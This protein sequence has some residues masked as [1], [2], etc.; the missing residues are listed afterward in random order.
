MFDQQPIPLP[1]KEKAWPTLARWVG[2]GVI[3]AASYGGGA[4]AVLNWPQATSSASEPPPAVM[5]ELAELPVSS[6][7]TPQEVAPGELM[8][9]AQPEETKDVPEPVKE[10]TEEPEPEPVPET[11][12]LVEQ[13]EPPP[14]PLPEPEIEVPDLPQIPLA[15]AVLTPPPPQPEKKVEKK[16]TPKEK[17][18]RKKTLSRDKLQAPRTTA[19]TASQAQ[20]ASRTAAPHSGASSAPSMS[21]ASWR[22]MLMAH[23]NRHKRF[24]PG[25]ST[26]TAVV[27]FRIDRG[28]RVVS[29]RLVRSSGDSALDAAAVG[30]V[31]R[32][33]PVPAPPSNM[34][35]GALSLT[36]PVRFNR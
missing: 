1:E 19:P 25:G 2:A 30:L 9:E 3:V 29:A 21:P 20:R 5:I 11:P 17:V 26:G 36:V 34:G 10:V 18:Q 12:K 4:W 6:Q 13:R 7:A 33:S 24:P 16:P 32:A 28:G 8:T 35:A 23:L 27:A 14:E 22:S 31:Q 15:E